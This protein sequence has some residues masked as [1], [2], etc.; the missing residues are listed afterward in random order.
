M[1]GVENG[2]RGYYLRRRT[3]GARVEEGASLL[4]GERAS[5]HALFCTIW[6]GPVDRTFGGGWSGEVSERPWCL[7]E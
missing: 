7:R 5:F 1:S 3:T 6:R 2:T 4:L